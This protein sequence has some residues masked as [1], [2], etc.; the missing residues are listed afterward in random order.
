MLQYFSDGYVYLPKL[1]GTPGTAPPIPPPSGGVEL[2]GEI[3]ADNGGPIRGVLT[4][5]SGDKSSE[6][7]IV[8]GASTGRYK[9]VQKVF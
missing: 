2:T 7:I 5:T 9:P 4:A 8:P 3:Y 1:K 6:F